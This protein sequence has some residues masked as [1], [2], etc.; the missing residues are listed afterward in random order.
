MLR[1]KDDCVPF[2][3]AEFAELVAGKDNFD[4][5]GIRMVYKIADDVSYQN[6]LGLNVLTIVIKEEDLMANEST[7]Y[8]IEKRLR[9]LDPE[10]HK[11][12][13]DIT[14][15]AIH[16]LSSYRRLFPE[17]TDHSELH[18]LTVIDSCNRLI[19]LEQIDK[20]NK[21]ELFVLLMAAYLHDSGMGI[22]EKDFEEFKDKVAD[23][24]FLEKHPDAD[25]ADFVRAY[26]N[27]FS[28]LFIEKYAELF[29]IPSPEYT[30]AV[31]QVARGHRK[32]DLYDENE[33]PAD[34]KLPN[35]NTVCLPYLASLIRLADEIDV[36]ASRNPLVLYDIGLLTN[37]TSIL[38]TRKLMAIDSVKMTRTAFILNTESK[39][40]EL[41][42][43]LMEM[44]GK[45]QQT[46]DTCRDVVNTRTQFRITQK[47][48]V[49]ARK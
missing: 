46:L 23:D 36:A 29:E 22:T 43:A 14:F 30:Y 32:T 12:F 40:E 3:P 2:D 15:T 35:G 5:M 10:L 41:I 44:I 11:R 28:G 1:L 24:S 33:Y 16:M 17:Y 39:D 47:E 31:K 8:L 42:E 25:M 20:L 45:M 49:L 19:G 13:R 18:S 34:Y 6:L 26:H 37:E 38:E 27:E 4:N 21:D 7:D 9:Q 48:V